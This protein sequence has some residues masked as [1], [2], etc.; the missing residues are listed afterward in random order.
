[1][2]R[3]AAYICTVT[4]LHENIGIQLTSSELTIQVISTLGA[5]IKSYTFLPNK[6]NSSKYNETAIIILFILLAVVYK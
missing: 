4:Y 6:G 1:M 3:V 5:V 2:L